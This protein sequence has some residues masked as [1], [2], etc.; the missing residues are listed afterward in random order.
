MLEIIG[1]GFGRTGTHSVAIAL[2]RLGFGPCYTIDEMGKNPSHHEIWQ[3]ALEGRPV[4]WFAL[5]ENYQSTM[6]WPAVSFLPELVDRF[7]EAKVILTIR[8]PEAWYESAASTIFPAL[9]S[10]A[11]HPNL[12]IRRKS[13]LK[14][15]LILERHFSG[16][17]WNK[18]KTI[19]AFQTHIRA[20]KVLVPKDRL[21]CFNV[22]EGWPPLCS[23]LGVDE[24]SEPFPKGNTQAD[25][26]ASSP[27][28]AVEVIE[29]NRKK[30]EQF[31]NNNL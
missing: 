22:K 7:P 15:K 28:W 9:E 17:Y 8:N 23:F 11:Q 30:R 12:E 3:N 21:L 13:S 1:A 20:V 31:L 2:D 10:T 4:D 19:G 18:S 24:P 14:R 16:N 29:T 6:E 26:M 27:K 25:F 5:L